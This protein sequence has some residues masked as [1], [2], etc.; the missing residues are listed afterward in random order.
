VHP[1]VDHYQTFDPAAGTCVPTGTTGAWYGLTGDSAGWVQASYDLS[2]YAG[3]SVEVSISYVL[4]FEVRGNGVQLDDVRLTTDGTSTPITGFET[5]LGGYT[6]SGPPEGSGSNRNDWARIGRVDLPGE[7][8]AGIVTTD[9][10]LLP[11]GL[12]QAPE[13]QRNQLVSGAMRWLLRRD[14]NPPPA[15]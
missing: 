9:T 6:V 5:D 10:V 7:P 12:E 8:A 4:D 14:E 1:F 15:P 2:A 11:F 13:A 3:Q